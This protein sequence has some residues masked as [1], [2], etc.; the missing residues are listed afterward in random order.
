MKTTQ[1]LIRARNFAIH[2]VLGLATLCCFVPFAKKLG[3]YYKEE[4][5]YEVV[6]SQQNAFWI[7]GGSVYYSAEGELGHLK[8]WFARAGLNPRLDHLDQAL[9]N[10]DDFESRLH[11]RELEM[12]LS[13]AGHE[14][15]ARWA[16]ELRLQ[17]KD[18]LAGYTA[19]LTAQ[20]GAE[21]VAERLA[22]PTSFKWASKPP[23]DGVWA[24]L[25]LSYFHSLVPVFLLLLFRV[26]KRGAGWMSTMAEIF[27]P[28]RLPLALFGYPL[29]MWSYPM[30]SPIQ[31][32]VVGSRLVVHYA[33]FAFLWFGAATKAGAQTLAQRRFQLP[34][35]ALVG[36]AG[37]SQDPVPVGQVVLP[38]QSSWFAIRANRLQVMAN[39]GN[40]TKTLSGE[41][42][43][44]GN[45]GQRVVFGGLGFCDMRR[46]V[47]PAQ[48]WLC[49]TQA[50]AGLK[51]LPAV[52]PITEF[53]TS[54]RGG[55]VSGGLRFNPLALKP[56]K[57]SF[58]GKAM[59]TVLVMPMWGVSG[60][61]PK[62]HVLVIA[63]T[64]NISVKGWQFF[65][66]GAWRV[67]P[68]PDYNWLDIRGFHTK[69]SWLALGCHWEPKSH[70][71]GCGPR[72]I[73]K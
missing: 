26:W 22:H 15:A 8:D 67:R 69:H 45:I 56:V 41:L 37:E 60:V 6:S 63:R 23:S 27:I 9:M 47:K 55:Y 72:L 59:K 36:A 48:V 30:M 25:K 12:A 58:V 20:F 49:N 33:M 7:A 14:F 2:A 57:A 51:K 13:E 32:M 10:L 43:F 53:G 29:L 4:G 31:S 46:H 38:K 40:D 5:R 35:P 24:A 28:W 52:S 19:K 50:F 1:F 21:A 17:A 62:R 16:N 39:A 44:G 73:A 64:S 42:G 18:Q 70:V 66:E 65:A 54:P 68:G 61:A 3:S 71:L 34:V 11:T